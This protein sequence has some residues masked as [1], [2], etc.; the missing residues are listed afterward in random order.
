MRYAAV[1]V[2]GRVF[3]WRAGDEPIESTVG[4]AVITALN[5]DD[6]AVRIAAMQ[7]LGAMRYE[8]GV[9]ALTDLFNYFKARAMR[10]KRR[11]TRSRTSATRPASRCSRRS[12]RART[13]RCAASPIEGLARAGDRAQ[14]PAIQA[15]VDQEHDRSVALAG[16]FASILLGN[17]SVDPVADALGR[18][19][20]ARAGQ[21]LPRRDRAR[22]A[23]RSSRTSCS[24]AIRKSASTLSTPSDSPGDPAAIAALEP[25]TNDKDPQVARAAE[26]AVAR[27]TAQTQHARIT[28]DTMISVCEATPAFLRSS[29][30]RRRAR[31]ARQS[32]RPQ[33][34]RRPHQRRD[35]RSRS[36]HRRIGSG[37]SCGA[38][39]DR[40]Q[41]ATLRDARSRRTST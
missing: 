13:R 36:L 3:A 20:P 35:R 15:L 10:P 23:P 24:T 9:Q 33:P 5:D 40:A 21:T 7:A 39:S 28:K 8:R 4:D 12:C 38:G 25:L 16:A 14:L 2:L 31:S 32:P 27:L 29:D 37:L 22:A 19:Q 34:P 17:G 26:R 41:P 18:P 30:A 11:S 1:R 6:R